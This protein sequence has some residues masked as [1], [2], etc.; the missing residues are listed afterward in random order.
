MIFAIIGWLFMVMELL[1]A[2]PLLAAAH[3]YAEGEGFA[4]QQ[5]SY[6]YDAAI[7]I[8]MR[9]VLLTFGFIIMFFMIFI[10]GHF[11]GSAMSVYMSG[12]NGFHLLHCKHDHAKPPT[13][14]RCLC[15]PGCCRPKTH[16]CNYP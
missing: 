10:V 11:V 12:M 5:T 1:V 16:P 4:P 7:G 9:P 2:A 8:V 6:G 15:H 13:L 3:A 14:L